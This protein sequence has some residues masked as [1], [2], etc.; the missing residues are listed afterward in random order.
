MNRLALALI[1]GLSATGA[2]AL[3]GE[4]NHNGQ[5]NTGTVNQA[6]IGGVNHNTQVNNSS[7]SEYSF[8]PGI[9][10]PTAGLAF[11]SSYAGAGDGFDGYSASVSYVMPLGGDIGSACKELALEITKQRQ[12]DTKLTMI[13]QCASFASSGIQLDTT[14]FPEF[15][16]CKGVRINGLSAV[17]SLSGFEQ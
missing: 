1:F 3:A 12:L 17:S 14:E 2:P 8:G 4:R 6:P 15:E 10:C 16:Q 13:K 9:N 11:S 7:I 5:S